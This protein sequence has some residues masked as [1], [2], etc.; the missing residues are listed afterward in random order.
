MPRSF[1]APVTAAL[2]DR[3]GRAVFA[4]G[5]GS[6][7]FETGEVAEAHDGAALSACVHPSGEGIVTGGDDGRLVWSRPDEALKLAD[8]KGRWIDAV[9]ASVESGL[10]AFA[11]GRSAIVL[12]Q[13]DPHFRR[14][15][16]HERTV[17]DVAFE[18]KGRKLA[19]ATYGG[20]VLW[21]ARIEQQ[22]PVQLK[23][24][25]SHTRVTVSPDGAFVVSAM[26]ENQLHG[27]R[28]KD[29]KDM[30]MGGYPAKIRDMTFLDGGRLMATS[31]AHG[32]VVWPF[33]G[34]NGPMGKE[35]A[36]VGF[37][38]ATFTVRTAGTPNGR[39]LAGGT[40]DG[41]V[42]VVDLGQGA[43]RW[44]KAEKAGAISGLA[45]TS[46]GRRLAWGD[47]DGGSAVVDL[48]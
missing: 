10:I 13:K 37:D 17:A 25:G 47:E 24:A 27:W 5:D 35:A 40:A 14:E 28:L 46:D 11:A 8:A 9:A 16:P 33:Q 23:W 26:Q 7:R 29:G 36:E 31:G 20:V 21:F 19:C 30:Q 34:S 3:T 2:F 22:K 41:R 44:L 32:A 45:L 38:E 18:P 42:W 12:D 6:V 1:D 4:L 15:F 43:H 39:R 48:D